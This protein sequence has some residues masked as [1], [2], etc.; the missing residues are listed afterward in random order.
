MIAI[1]LYM[2]MQIKLLMSKM[3][4][5]IGRKNELLERKMEGKKPK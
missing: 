4:S 2:N 1:I 5:I 3:L